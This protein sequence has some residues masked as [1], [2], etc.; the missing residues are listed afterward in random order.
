MT[1]IDEAVTAAGGQGPLAEA[2]GVTQS[3]VSRWVTQGWV[4]WQKWGV[5][6]RAT[7]VPQE[8]LAHPQIAAVLFKEWK[9]EQEAP[10]A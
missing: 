7:G 5:V 3:A 8:R 9:A 4:P 6:T 2:C 10:Q 1:G